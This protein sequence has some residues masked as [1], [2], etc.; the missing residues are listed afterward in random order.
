MEKKYYLTNT[1][2]YRQWY[3]GTESLRLPMLVLMTMD[4]LLMC[5][6]KISESDSPGNT[7][8]MGKY[9][10]TAGVQFGWIGFY[11]TRKYV[12]K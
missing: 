4:S 12:V 6:T 11:L 7:H 5:D 1:S 10:N 9:Q 3:L 2:T 8:C